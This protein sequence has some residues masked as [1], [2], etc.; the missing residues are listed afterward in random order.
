MKTLEDAF[1]SYLEEA[2]GASESATAAAEEPQVTP[3]EPARRLPVDEREVSK[4]RRLYSYLRLEV[5]ELKRDPIRLTIAVLGSI[6]LM[7]IMGYGISMDVENLTFAALDYDQ[8][9][10]SREL[11]AQPRRLALFQRA[12]TA[13]RLCGYGA[14][15][16][17]RRDQF[18]HRDPS[19]IRA[20]HRP[21]SS[22]ASRRMD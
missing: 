8:T 17:F 9:T 6:I 1:I 12:R 19:Q 10:T 13:P 18:G 21:W 20:R 3:V 15:L 14:A 5:L 22:R 2:T 7:F 16:A 11:C 4:L